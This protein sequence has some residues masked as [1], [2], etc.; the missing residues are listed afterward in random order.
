[1]HII[2]AYLDYLISAYLNIKYPL[3]ETS[4]ELLGLIFAYTCFG[5]TIVMMPIYL[6]YTLT[7]P[8]AY[9]RDPKLLFL[10]NLGLIY[11]ELN[12]HHKLQLAYFVFYIL[13]RILYVLIFINVKYQAI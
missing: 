2:E 8:I 3:S 11:T 13:R 5:F 1:M 7:R 4:G 9:F 12:T 6:L 10:K